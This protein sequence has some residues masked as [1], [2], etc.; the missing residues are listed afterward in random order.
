MFH[1]Y[2]PR[3]AETLLQEKPSP[4]AESRGTGTVLV[5]DDE[6]LVLSVAERILSRSGY[7]V[8]T[9]RDGREGLERARQ[10]K[11]AIDLAILD[12]QMP[13][14]DGLQLRG[15][16]PRGGSGGEGAAFERLQRNG[17]RSGGV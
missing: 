2:L 9:A 5:V 7:S 17:R 10:H 1:V 4:S 16:A 15:A 12:V 11:G 13:Y 6:A 3:G 14:L 8:L